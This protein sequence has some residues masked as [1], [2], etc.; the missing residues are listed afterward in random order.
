[1]P[2]SQAP[3]GPEPDIELAAI[4]LWRQTRSESTDWEWERVNATR[5]DAYRRMALAV[6]SA[7][8]CVNGLQ[9]E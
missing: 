8:G 4:E 2:A 1:M 7:A 6:L 5:K 9:A 3:L